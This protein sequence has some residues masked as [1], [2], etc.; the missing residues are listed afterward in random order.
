MKIGI[1]AGETSGDLLGASLIK[2]VKRQVP[3]A[4]FVGIAGPRMQS[5]G[6]HTL[7]P[8]EKLAVRGYVEVLRHFR[9]LLGIRKQLMRY[10]LSERPSVF[11]GIDAPD[12]NLG[13]EAKLKAAGI[14]TIQYVGPQ[15]W[16]WRAD[17]ME[18]IK[19]AVS[20]VLTLFPFETELYERA[21]VPVSF[22]GHPLADM[23]PLQFDRA[24]AR[25]QM[26][27]ART[28][29]VIALLP[30]SRVSEL[31]YHA[32][33]FVQTAAALLRQHPE[34]LF[35]VPLVSQPTRS[36]F[37]QALASSDIDPDR[38]RLM[39]AHAQHALA[40]A[41]VALVASGTA[42]LEAALFK[43]P[44]IITYRLS[45]LSYYLMSRKMTLPFVGLRNVLANEFVV[46]EYVQD[47]ATPE[48]LA[49]ALSDLLGD[50]E[51]RSKMLDHF[52]RLHESL[53]QDNAERTAQAVLPYLHAAPRALT[54]AHAA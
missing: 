27:L 7:F 26:R 9:E 2:A 19:R 43:C 29:P 48:K 28:S 39:H 36:L 12:F 52:A 11:I 44:M 5:A 33:L 14:P 18:G 10:F 24:E 21:G 15:V 35:L 30:G 34:A 51:A 38:V 25:A 32:Q 31:Q 17:R 45:K 3:E 54:G 42:T 47:D 49:A 53:R 1:V 20:R 40:C 8:M 6:A 4:E 50:K 16:A 46:P 22:V 23:V 41:D 37:E 13:L